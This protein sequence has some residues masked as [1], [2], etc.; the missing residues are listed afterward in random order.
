MADAQYCRCGEPLVMRQAQQGNRAGDSYFSCPNYVS[1]QQPGC[2][3]FRW[4]NGPVT[5]HKQTT[6]NQPSKYNI[7]FAQK[8]Q[9][10]PAPD[11]IT[12]NDSAKRLA[13][14]INR[15]KATLDQLQSCV[16]KLYQLTSPSPEDGEIEENEGMEN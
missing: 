2:G 8:P 7:T 12:D 6:H 4:V 11:S 9:Q 15:L 16:N 14:Q 13:V 3:Y 1:K 10:H 5:T